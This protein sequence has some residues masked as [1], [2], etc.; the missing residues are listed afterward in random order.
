M[1]QIAFLVRTLVVVISFAAI[2]FSQT[3]Q[4]TGTVTDQS[5]AVVPGTKV[6]ATNVDTGVARSSVANQSGNYLIT[7]LLPGSYRVTA[8]SPGFKQVARELIR[9]EVD[10]VARLDFSL[11]VGETRDTVSV[12]ATAVL[13]DSA[14]STIGT[15]VESRQ[16]SELPLNG[17]NPID[18]LAL[19]AGIRIQAGFGGRSVQSG[20]PGGTYQGF[21]FNGGIA[22][23]NAT[24]V[25]GLALDMAQMNAPSFVPPA[26]A[27]QEF[28]AQTNKFSAEYG[29][30]TGAVISISIKS[31]TNTF[32]GSLYEYLR[33]RNLN[34]N[35]FFQNRA[36]NRRAP[37]N[38]NEFGGTLGGPIKRDKT[39]FFV[40]VD[41]YRQVAGAPAITSVPTALQAA[42]NFSQT[43]TAAGALVAIADPLT[44]SPRQVFPGN[45]IP[46]NRISRVA[47]NVVKAFPAPTLAGQAFTNVNNYST[48]AASR[49]NEHQVISKI[50]HNLNTRWKIFG[51]YSRDW[52]DQG[53]D[54]PFG[55]EP[56][57]TRAVKN[58]RN[59]ATVSATA[60]FSP[61]LIGEFRTGFARLYFSSFPNALG[62]DITTLGFPKAFADQAQI[63]SYPSFAVAGMAG[64]GGSGSAGQS[65]GGMNSWGQRAALTWVKGTH[66]LKFGGDYRI[67]Q[68][69]QFLA[70]SL[71]PLFNFTNQM[72]AIN[73]L[74]LNAASGVPMASFMLGYVSSASIAKSQHL[75]N[76]RKY[77]SMF[78]QD[79]W[80]LTRKLTLNVG[81][82]YSLEFPIT[83]R[84]NR[85][86]WLDPDVLL[87]ISQAVGLPLRGGF[88]FADKNTRSPFDLYKTQFGPRFGLA[89]QLTPGTV[90]RSGYGLFWIPAAMTEV[91]GDTRA[92]AWA[93]NT[94]MVTTLDGGVT[95]YNT[96]D[97]PYPT[98]LQEPPGNSQGLNSLIGQDAAANLRRYHSGY[99]QQ[100][101]FSIQKEMMKEAVLEVSYAGSA[102]VGLPAGFATQQNQLPDRYLSLGASL[103][104][105]VPN[106]FF[107]VV[108][109]G[110]LAQR[111]VQRAQLLRPYPQFTTLFNE[112]DAIGHSSYHSLQV[113]YKQRFGAA[114]VTVAYT[115]SKAIGDT[116]ARLDT[117]GNSTNAGFLNIYNRRQNRA[118]SAYDV[119]Q[120][121]AVSYA[122]ELPF[123]KGRRLLTNLGPLNR[124]VSGWQLNGI[125]SAQSGRPIGVA[126]NTN[127]TGNFTQ[128]TDVYGTFVSNAVPN[129]NGKSAKLDGPPVDRLNRWF[130]ISTFS[131]PAAFT[132]GTSARTLPDV[133]SHGLNNLD[134]S[135]F[136]N[137]PFGKGER[138]NL[139]FR[140][141]FF[142]VANHVQFGFPAIAFGNATFGVIS[143]QGNNPRQIQLALKLQF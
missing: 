109:S 50:D 2:A 21:S 43:F 26:D 5:A 57:L 27:T 73:P 31:G 88:Q 99:M 19:S 59:H 93:I 60:V 83:E 46:A 67:Q 54:D 87:P 44:A 11:E 90:I 36:G 55:F 49:V 32:H 91:T 89:Y 136:K 41:E 92:P 114:L 138:F 113:Q 125:Y 17:R 63:K 68:M 100:W 143:S 106:P 25:E 127:L 70:N 124:V 97:N 34:A 53:N 139:Q 111:T 81:M 20:T 16:I 142:N 65:F 6:T 23:S 10:Q 76:Q 28:R 116:E 78:V 108:Q 129:N 66:T 133:R 1:Q 126:T 117:G 61:S 75:A 35:N 14:T 112:G 51:T 12:E 103:N 141:E 30:T 71:L 137:N 101:N 58:I 107:G 13:L 86:M 85:K 134:F 7:A 39:F 3:A 15:T 105:L 9:L 8:E 135:L 37:F 115:A 130:D 45:I 72:S 77:L 74:S 98:G 131:Q 82:D 56:K 69:N 119:P 29:R 52:L 33:N 47:S 40:N 22:G 128:I 80:K 94:P 64:I 18:L 62:F 48:R 123:G 121:L 38:Q 84:Y 118:L 4:L 122:W 42:G 96:L 102:G 110:A 104:D 24:L 79:D 132:Y 95:P 140:A 120:R